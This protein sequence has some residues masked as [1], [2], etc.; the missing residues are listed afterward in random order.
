[1]TKVLQEVIAEQ[2]AR[3]HGLQVAVLRMGHVIDL[4]TGKNKYDHDIP[5]HT[6]Y[7]TD[8]H[9]IAE[10]AL[11]CLA[12]DGLTYE[13]FY[14]TSFRMPSAGPFGPGPHLQ[15]AELAAGAARSLITRWATISAALPGDIARAASAIALRLSAS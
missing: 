12:L 14:I 10:A 11:R 6:V 5:Q 4:A 2:F 13:T 7:E 3:D 9:D 8:R 1:M 15:A